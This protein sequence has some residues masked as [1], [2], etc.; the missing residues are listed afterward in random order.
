MALRDSYPTYTFGLETKHA[1]RC[2][3][4]EEMVPLTESVSA[5]GSRCALRRCK[6]CHSSRKA[7]RTWF[8]NAKR[9][10]EWEQMSTE[11][12]RKLII[13][14]KDKGCGRGKRRR[15]L[16]DEKATCTD[17]VGLRSDKP[18]MTRKQFLSSNV[19]QH[20][21]SSMNRFLLVSIE[22]LWSYCLFHLTLPQDLTW[23]DPSRFISALR[24]RYDWSDAELEAE[25]ESSKTN[26]HAIWA[27]DEYGQWTVSL[28]RSSTASSSRELAHVKGIQQ[29]EEIETDDVASALS[30]FLIQQ[31]GFNLKCLITCQC[32]KSNTISI[33]IHVVIALISHYCC[34]LWILPFIS[35]TVNNAS[36]HK[37][38][39][40][41]DA[42]RL[43]LGIGSGSMLLHGISTLYYASVV[44]SYV[45][46]M[47]CQ[48]FHW[49]VMPRY[50][51][52]PVD[53]CATGG[54]PASCDFGWGIVQGERRETQGQG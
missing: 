39:L 6:K 44:K 33:V 45:H 14:N 43:V 20:C 7:L 34:R 28:L 21:G 36:L 49:C 26:P 31:S 1:L 50:E 3:D 4:C 8:S 5:G 27:K 30:S 19:L 32:N 15:I 48:L 29:K 10:E 35:G 42:H 12:R 9:S 37:E 23:P 17:S 51:P 38:S 52:F 40:I 24:D 53:A 22:F 13:Q 41:F 18:F 2:A 16:V 54:K 11:E 46:F 25:W 47:W